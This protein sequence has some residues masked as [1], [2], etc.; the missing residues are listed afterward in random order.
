MVRAKEIMTETCVCCERETGVERVSVLMTEHNCGCIPVVEGSASGRLVGIITDRD[1]VCRVIAK[2]KDPRTERAGT[3]MTAPV[4]VV[5]EDTPIR[6]CSQIMERENVRRLPVVDGEG[7]CCGIISQTDIAR[8][9]ARGGLIQR[10]YRSHSGTE[11]GKV[12]P[13]KH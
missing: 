6:E 1:I 2:G 12:S 9:A 8:N 11:F 3:Y 13:L 5:S 10:L 7:R 4:S